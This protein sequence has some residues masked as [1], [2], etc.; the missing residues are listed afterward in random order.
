MAVLH[1]PSTIPLPI[2]RPSA[3]R[4]RSGVWSPGGPRE[5]ASA[6]APPGEDREPHLAPPAGG[7]DAGAVGL[8]LGV[9]LGLAERPVRLGVLALPGAHQA[10]VVVTHL[11]HGVVA[12]DQPG[13]VAQVAGAALEG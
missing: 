5:P 1:A 4:W 6:A 12:D 2:D 9:A 10:A 7:V 8:E 11:A 13:D 3:N